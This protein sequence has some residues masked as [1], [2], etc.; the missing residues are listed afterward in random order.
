MMPGASSYARP[1]SAFGYWRGVG[2]DGPLAYGQGSNYGQASQ[3]A[4]M[5]PQGYGGPAP[6]AGGWHPTVIYLIL[7]VIAEMIIFKW[8]GKVLS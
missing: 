3:G 4:G 5:F 7:F 6:A 2:S 1:S 8:V